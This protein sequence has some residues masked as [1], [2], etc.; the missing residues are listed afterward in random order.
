MAVYFP[1]IIRIK[2]LV[3]LLLLTILAITVQAED[4][5]VRNL[6]YTAAANRL[7]QLDLRA[8]ADAVKAP[9]MIM[10]H[11]GGWSIGDKDNG[12]CGITGDRADYYLKQGFIYVSVNYR[13]SPLIHH[14][15][16]VRDVAAALAFIHRHIAEYGGDP[17]RLYLMG[18]SAGAHLAALVAADRRF[19]EQNGTPPE[20]LRGVILLDGAAYDIPAEYDRLDR[21]G[22]GPLF[23]MYKEAF[24]AVPATQ[25][26]ASPTLQ[27]KSGYYLPPFLMFYIQRPGAAVQNQRLA[28]AIIRAGG[29]AQTKLAEGKTHMTLNRDFGRADDPVTAAAA[30]FIVAHP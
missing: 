9:V 16:H 30:R 15:E 12:N 11:G 19:L 21:F 13:L 22:A 17:Q 24:T 23:K 3:P 18:H 28:E 1:H 10:I 6:N 7:Q 8:P 20:C 14:P 5:V 29:Q 25:R 27:V 4:K 2:F 26:D